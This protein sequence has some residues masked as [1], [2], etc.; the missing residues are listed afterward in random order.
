MRAAI[1]T[2]VLDVS[3]GH[4]AEGVAVILNHPSGHIFEGQTDADGRI[5]DWSES[6]DLEPGQY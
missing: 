6:F 1:T 2:H 3:A 5:S 4:P